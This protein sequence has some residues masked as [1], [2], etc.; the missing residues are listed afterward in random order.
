MFSGTFGIVISD[1]QNCY[2][3][4]LSAKSNASWGIQV[5][6]DTT[7]GNVVRAPNSSHNGEDGLRIVGGEENI[8]VDFTAV[9]NKGNGVVI[10]AC[11][12]NE[13]LNGLAKENGGDGIK[14]VNGSH[15]NRIIGNATNKNGG[16]G[17]FISN[18]DQKNI[19]GLNHAKDNFLNQIQDNGIATELIGNV[20]D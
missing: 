18:V 4:G 2:F 15:R 17:I 5:Q 10:T 12:N 19:V 8:Y 13:V 16:N 11:S 14:T 6:E 9:G 7:L 1:C 3:D 20:I